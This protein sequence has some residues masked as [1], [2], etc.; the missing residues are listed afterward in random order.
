LPEIDVWS[1]ATS[2]LQGLRELH[3]RSILH[4]DLKPANVFLKRGA[5]TSPSRAC[6]GRSGSQN[7]CVAAA[8]GS[9]KFNVLVGDLGLARE[10][11]ESHPLASTM[12]G[13]PLYCA[14][15][16][17]EGQ[18]YGEKADVYSFGVCVYELMHGRPPF[19]AVQNMGALVR[20]VLNLDGKSGEMRLPMNCQY[21]CNLRGLV[22]SCLAISP[23]QR[24]PV[25]ELLNRVAVLQCQSPTWCI[26]QKHIACA[27]PK[28]DKGAT[29]AKPLVRHSSQP[30]AVLARSPAKKPSL[31]RSPSVPAV[32]TKACP[33]RQV[34]VPVSGQH[35]SQCTSSPGGPHQF[36]PTCRQNEEDISAE[37]AIGKVVSKQCTHRTSQPA[38]VSSPHVANMQDEEDA[39]T[40]HSSRMQPATCGS[41]A[42]SSSAPAFLTDE[43]VEPLLKHEDKIADPDYE[44]QS[45]AS[46]GACVKPNAE[47]EAQEPL[48]S[49]LLPQSPARSLTIGISALSTVI[50]VDACPEIGSVN[51]AVDSP[52]VSC[53]A[54]LKPSEGQSLDATSPCLEQNSRR[55]IGRQAATS[56]KPACPV[57]STSG[58]NFSVS[59]HSLRGSCDP[60]CS[61]PSQRPP[62]RAGMRQRGKAYV[63]KAQE[64]WSKWRRQRLQARALGLYGTA[65]TKGQGFGGMRSAKSPLVAQH[66]AAADMDETLE[67]RGVAPPCTPVR[68]P[69]S[70][71]NGRG[72]MVPARVLYSPPSRHIKGARV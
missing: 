60:I 65:E 16:I 37:T 50:D 27:E 45:E 47:Q 11:S 66:G 63:A 43:R 62:G 59:G 19:G 36:Q 20:Q 70:K 57:Q 52:E 6:S 30:R 41:L 7:R 13:T 40:L 64:C 22:L 53:E 42:R 46:T 55:G 9:F 26:A 10:M 58:K 33:G 12:V 25:T 71:R 32:I 39:V 44:Q 23:D 4:R 28:A 67:I 56:R 1:I 17:F 15:E 5:Q 68:T 21:S 48:P 8:S 31:T 54:T 72:S 49:A 14:P 61:S 34:R 2:T 24:P 29:S 38:P 51:A 35:E 3:A 18:P 69:V